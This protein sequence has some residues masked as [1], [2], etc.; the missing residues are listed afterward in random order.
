MGTPS[1]INGVVTDKAGGPSD[2]RR[3]SASPRVAPSENRKDANP[4]RHGMCWPR[5]PVFGAVLEKGTPTSSVGRGVRALSPDTRCGPPGLRSFEAACAPPS[6]AP[7]TNPPLADRCPSYAGSQGTGTPPGIS[8]GDLNQYREA[9]GSANARGVLG[10]SS[11]DD[12]TFAA[13][14]PVVHAGRMRPH[15]HIPC[16]TPLAGGRCFACI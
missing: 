7:P 1:L 3:T 12:E 4:V 15:P 13:P 16:R 10:V 2:R 11:P 9:R 6:M 5:R 14:E 8:S